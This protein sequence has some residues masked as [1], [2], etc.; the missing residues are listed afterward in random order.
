MLLFRFD[1]DK[2]FQFRY[3]PFFSALASSFLCKA[4][5]GHPQQN[6][7]IKQVVFVHNNSCFQL[8]SLFINKSIKFNFGT[9]FFFWSRSFVGDFN[10]IA[11]AAKWIKMN[12][13]FFSLEEPKC[14][15]S[16]S[17]STHTSQFNPYGKINLISNTSFG[18]LFLCVS[19][20]S[21]STCTDLQAHKF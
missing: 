18:L 10:A 15:L 9:F 12:G 19:I 1:T 21:S 7:C 8:F 20:I 2:H 14:T 4:N 17:T 6:I 13:I 11:E 16:T 5:V 3:S